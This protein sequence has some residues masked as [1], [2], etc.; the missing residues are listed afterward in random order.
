[1]GK[2]KEDIQEKRVA[3]EELE[4]NK[5]DLVTEKF[6]YVDKELYHANQH[7]EAQLLIKKIQST[8]ICLQEVMIE[9]TDYNI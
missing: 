5:Y 3:C 1:M 6:R 9:D 2:E 4:Y 8:C 7:K